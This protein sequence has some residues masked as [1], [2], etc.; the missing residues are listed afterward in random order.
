MVAR[1]TPNAR[2][3]S[4]TQG[5]RRVR[6]HGAP[7]RYGTTREMLR[8]LSG[9]WD[10]EMLPPLTVSRGVASVTCWTTRHN[11]G[12]ILQYCNTAWARSVETAEWGWG[13]GGGLPS[14]RMAQCHL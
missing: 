9:E 13:P 1:P 4:G 2:E 3:A 6:L 8:G 12:A 11:T 14:A 10:R 5:T 7:A